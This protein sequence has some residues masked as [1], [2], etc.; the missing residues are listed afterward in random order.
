MATQSTEIQA[1]GIVVILQGNAW[2]EDKNGN[3]HPLKVGDELEEGQKVVTADG[4]RLELALPNGQPLLIE[5]GRE[6]VLDANLLG[7]APQDRTESALQ[8]LNGGASDIAKVIASGG[9]LSE[10]LEATAAG[11]GGGQGGEAHSF[12]RLTR[13]S[14]GLNDLALV[15]DDGQNSD[16]ESRF[17]GASTQ[18]LTVTGAS[19][20]VPTVSIPN[21]GTGVGGSD[22]SVAE[23][24]TTTG[25]FTISAPDGLTSLTIGSTVITAT[26]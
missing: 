10:Q 24:A 6:L 2:V 8:S 12:V 3:R 4:T 19:E 26:A 5:A 16:E 11:L 23:N 7:I 18:A 1:R 15:R 17:T 25:S 9:D 20:G 13:I 21:N 14:E 22:L